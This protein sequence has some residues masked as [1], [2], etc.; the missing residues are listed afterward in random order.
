LEKELYNIKE[1]LWN[2]G[3]PKN[4]VDKAI[5]KSLYPKKTFYGPDKKPIYYGLYYNG[6]CTDIYVKNLRKMFSKFAPGYCRLVVYFKRSPSLIHT[7]SSG[8]KMKS[9]STLGVVYQIK[10]NE[11]ELSYVGQTGRQL[12]ARLKEHSRSESSDKPSA[13]MNHVKTTGHKMNYTD[14]V[15]LHHEKNV[16]KRQILESLYMTKVDRFEENT[17]S[18][19]LSIF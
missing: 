1:L 19:E 10:C 2:S 14:S 8:Y 18:F 9:Y 6:K 3:Y 12:C 15:I 16:Y 4:F 7:F 11:C 5:K 17:Y 13:I